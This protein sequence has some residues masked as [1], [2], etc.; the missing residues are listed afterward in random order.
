MSITEDETGNSTASTTLPPSD[1]SL[2]LEANWQFSMH[3]CRSIQRYENFDYKSDCYLDLYQFSWPKH[4]HDLFSK[5]LPSTT[6]LISRQ[7]EHAFS[8]TKNSFANKDQ[9][10]DTTEF[11]NAIVY[12]LKQIFGLRE[13]TFK[14]KQIN[15]FI[16]KEQKAFIKNVMCYPEQIREDDYRS[17][18]PSLNDSEKCH[19]CI[20]ILETKKRI[21]LTY[22]ARAL[23]QFLN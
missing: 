17:F 12:Y 7:M 21:G 10:E 15:E 2:D 9:L 8:M 18:M 13:E 1:P 23:S 16:G 3:L 5:F 22:I 20:L 6:K 11:R 14:F 4:G 19:I